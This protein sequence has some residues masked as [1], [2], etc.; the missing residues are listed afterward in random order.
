MAPAPTDTNTPTG[1]RQGPGRA[2]TVMCGMIGAMTEP[3]TLQTRIV[4]M[5][6]AGAIVLTDEQVALLGGGRKPPVRVQ[7]ADASAR[8]RVAV[9][10]GQNLIGLSKAARAQLGVEVGDQVS[11]VVCLDDAP[12]HVDVPDDLAAALASADLT[13]LFD[14]LAYT[15]R[16]EF[17]TW[18]ADAKRADTRARRI[19][20]TL[21]MVREGRTRS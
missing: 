16:K 15:Y 3:L 21:D 13:S 17:A 1:P 20:Q 14:R 4:P 9:M 8:L 18:V 12:R 19:A 11:A 5:G 6:P 2:A 7:I 10:G